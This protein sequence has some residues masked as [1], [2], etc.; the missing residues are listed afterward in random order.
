[1]ADTS[2]GQ[3]DV[4]LM[5]IND[6][7][8]PRFDIDRDWHGE[9]TKLG[10]LTRNIPAEVQAMAAG[11]APGQIR[12]GLR[13]SRELIPVM[14]R[15]TAGLGKDRFFIEPLAYHNAIIFERYGF[16]YMRGRTKMEQI[17]AGFQPGEALSE[18]MDG[19]TPF[20]Q[21]GAEHTI[22]GRSWAI[23]DGVLGEPWSDV[24]M[25]KRIDHRAGV[26]TFPD[27]IY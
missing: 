21:P 20:R 17:Q 11:L 23:H 5:Q 14:E 13:L 25:Y 3:L 4:L 19:S 6:P 18:Q 12:R 7:H 10:T 2:S 26:C 1:M 27:A 22:R 24:R 15:F 16:A 8:A 9:T